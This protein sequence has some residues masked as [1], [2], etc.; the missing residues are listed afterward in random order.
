MQ[1]NLSKFVVFFCCWLL[2][3]A[4]VLLVCFLQAKVYDTDYL[5]NYTFLISFVVAFVCVA[6]WNIRYKDI[7]ENI[8][9]FSFL[10]CFNMLL[11]YIAPLTVN[12]S[13]STFIYFYSVENK[14][15]SK[16]IYED[17]YYNDFVIRRFEDGENFGFLE[18]DKNLCKPNIKTK[19]FYYILMPLGKITLSDKHYKEFK[20]FAD[21]Y[22]Q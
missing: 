9:L 10:L 7:F 8:L 1:S 13:L 18:C 22:N 20:R 4:L 19:I 17:G 16:K 15:I 3:I 14:Q 5:F 6:L 2:S 11:I 21:K 12:R